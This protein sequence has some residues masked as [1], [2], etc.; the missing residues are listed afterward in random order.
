MVT[1]TNSLQVKLLS[2]NVEN[3]RVTSLFQDLDVYF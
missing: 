3:V 2:A 1:K